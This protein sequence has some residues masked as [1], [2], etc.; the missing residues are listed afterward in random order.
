[1]DKFKWCITLN[2]IFYSMGNNGFSNFFQI[3]GGFACHYSTLEV[4][5]LPKNPLIGVFNCNFVILFEHRCF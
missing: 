2:Y 5:I 4:F 3:D 1:M